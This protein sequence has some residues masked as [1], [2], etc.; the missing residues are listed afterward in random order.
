MSELAYAA[1][2]TND[3][4]AGKINWLQAL[5]MFI[6]LK[7]EIDTFTKVLSVIGWLPL[8]DDWADL[9]PGPNVWTI[10]NNIPF[11]IFAVTRITMI[12]V[13]H[14]REVTL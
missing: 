10:G 6:S 3:V 4:T 2:A 7:G 5:W 11:A 12:M 13:Q 1:Q 14:N 8:I 9:I